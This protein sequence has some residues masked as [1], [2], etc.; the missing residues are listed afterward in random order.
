MVVLSMLGFWLVPASEDMK[1]NFRLVIA[2][3][4]LCTC[5]YCFLQAK[6]TLLVRPHPGFWR[7]I[8]GIGLFYFLFLATILILNVE[9]GRGLMRLVTHERVSDPFQ[10]TVDLQCQWTLTNWKIQLSKI[11]TL[12][13]V[14]GF[15]LKMCIF[16]DWSFCL[17]NSLLFE[18]C[19]LSFQWLVPELQECWW[20]SLILD[21][22]CNVTG[23]F[24]GTLVLRFFKSLS[25]DWSGGAPTM[26]VFRSFVL[27]VAT[28]FYWSRWDWGFFLTFDRLL[29]TGY[30]MIFSLVLELNTFLQMYALDVPPPPMSWLLGARVILICALSVPA[31]AEHYDYTNTRRRPGQNIWLICCLAI[32]EILVC[33]KYGA[34]RFS[35]SFPG[36]SVV[37]PHLL[38]W[39]LLS[40]WC[41]FRFAVVGTLQA[42]VQ[43]ETQMKSSGVFL[44]FSVSGKSQIKPLRNN[45]EVEMSLDPSAACTPRSVSRL[46][47]PT[48]SFN[49]TGINNTGINNTGGDGV[50][51]RRRQLSLDDDVS[52]LSDGGHQGCKNESSTTPL[53]IEKDTKKRRCKWGV[54]YIVGLWVVEVPVFACFTPLLVL[55]RNY[56]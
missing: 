13:H 27:R 29:L 56:M 28:P 30:M 3:L 5:T 33:A 44:P 16:R 8:H 11:W 4:L 15:I 43:A 49:N 12:C 9:L 48:V 36:M 22:I 1:A 50:R 54:L 23:M 6:D 21:T 42:Q 14:G 20:D 39:A 25:Y 34:A 51:N 46:V 38:S 26:G 35:K 55:M 7:I 24:L 32:M 31:T 2:A 52:I 47:T 53:E 10:G 37:V 19:E 41:F 45:D 17:A 18:F 40:V